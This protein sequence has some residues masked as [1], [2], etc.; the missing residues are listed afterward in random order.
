MGRAVSATPE[1]S[2]SA[3]GGVITRKG[4]NLI[5]IQ[6]LQQWDEIAPVSVN[7]ARQTSSGSSKSWVEQVEEMQEEPEIRHSIWDNFD[8]AKGQQQARP[9]AHTAPKQAVVQ[10]T[11]GQA[12]S[13]ITNDSKSVGENVRGNHSKE[14][15]A[16]N[17]EL[18]TP[19][20]GY[21]TQQHVLDKVAQALSQ[22]A[23][24]LR[25]VG[26]GRGK[27]IPVTGNG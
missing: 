13:S 26:N 5:E 23:S 1:E 6:Q 9:N 27:P 24:N 19:M 22:I 4:P 7:S 18:V 17:V 3:I 8:I 10:Q 14:V 25:S 21:T 16:L 15:G 12:G 11:Q 20:R 2:R